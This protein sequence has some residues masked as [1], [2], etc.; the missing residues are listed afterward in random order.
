M[1]DQNIKRAV[2]YATILNLGKYSKKVLRSLS[3]MDELVETADPRKLSTSLAKL[4]S[5]SNREVSKI[6]NEC[7]KLF[8]G[9]TDEY[10]ILYKKDLLYPKL[11]KKTDNAP[12]FLF[13]QGDP[14]LF[15]NKCISVVG[16]RKPSDFGLRRA[17]KLAML[18][19]A[20][21]YAVVSGLARGIDTAAHTGAIKAGGQTI[22]VIGTPLD[23]SYPKENSALQKVIAQGHL[24]AP[25]PPGAYF[26]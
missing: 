17:Q 2:N 5:T 4:F 24:H 21:G 20:D 8:Q 25:L 11:L 10:Q 18:L 9:Y 13:C 14:S 15:Y 7:L 16:T 23:K 12:L 6:Y 26:G 3:Q 1:N 19:V 22:G